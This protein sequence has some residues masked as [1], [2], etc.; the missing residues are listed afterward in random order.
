MILKT[1]KI[2]LN[3]EQL[4]YLIKVVELDMETLEENMEHDVLEGEHKELKMIQ[5]LYSK[6]VILN[7]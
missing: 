1:S 4:D 5:D 6:L 7:K 3:T 2:E